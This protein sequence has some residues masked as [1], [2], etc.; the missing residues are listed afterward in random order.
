[1]RAVFGI[2]FASAVEATDYCSA[3]E[4]AD[5][6]SKINKVAGALYKSSV[7]DLTDFR[8]AVH[9][10]IDPL[11]TY[12]CEACVNGHLMELYNLH[13]TTDGVC[14]GAE[15]T[16]ICGLAQDARECYFQECAMGPDVACVMS[17]ANGLAL[18]AAAI[19]AALAL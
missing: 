13:L 15:S 14:Y 4:F 17:G 11:D 9:E 12:P 3:T 8:T 19:I 2:V 10:S 18:A 1:M 5:L 16:A 6:N 7:G